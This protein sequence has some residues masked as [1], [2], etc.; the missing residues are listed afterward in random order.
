MPIRHAK[1]V[2]RK[3]IGKKEKQ[4]KE[5]YQQFVIIL[6]DNLIKE[7]FAFFFWMPKGTRKKDIRDRLIAKGGKI[8]II[9]IHRVNEETKQSIEKRIELL[10]QRLSGNE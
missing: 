6:R 4:R 8:L 10:N 3:V 5:K 9:S 1:K 2:L 7:H